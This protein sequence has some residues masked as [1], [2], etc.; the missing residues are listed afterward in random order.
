[1]CGRRLTARTSSAF[2]TSSAGSRNLFAS[3]HGLVLATGVAVGAGV[4]A[5]AFLRSPL[6]ADATSSDASDKDANWREKWRA[7]YNDKIKNWSTPE[8]IFNVFATVRKN[9]E[10]FMTV[11]DFCDAIL[12][13]DH[14]PPSEKGKIKKIPDFI[15]FADLDG[16]ELISFGEYSFFTTLLSLPEEHFKIAFQ[17]F[18]LDGSGSI[19]KQEFRKVLRVLRKESPVGSQQTTHKKEV[20]KSGIYTHFFGADG[21]KELTAAEFENFIK[22]L[23]QGVLQLEFERF[24]AKGDGK[25]TAR[26]FGMSVIGYVDPKDLPSFI[27]RADTLDNQ[28]GELTF[29][30]FVNFNKALKKLPEIAVAVKLYAQGGE[31]NKHD[32]GRAVKA[33]SGVDLKPV[34][35]DV[36]FHVLDKD[37]NGKLD[38]NELLEVMAKR[39]ERGMSHHRDV[40]VARFFNCLVSCCSRRA[41]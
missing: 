41:I 8:K 37:G 15:R 14:R 30:D 24:D 9:G 19:S 12:P 16:D 6:L 10:H 25:I 4:F 40:G 26:A 1:L 27:A 39:V 2:Y 28:K 7:R 32:F 23:H 20:E 35:V 3:S 11:E 33:I 38:H 36:I 5:S 21:K 31:I 22:S 34:Q 13:A 29:E 17:M 18:D